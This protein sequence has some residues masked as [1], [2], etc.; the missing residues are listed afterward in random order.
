MGTIH[1]ILSNE[2][3][4]LLHSV[5]FCTYNIDRCTRLGYILGIPNTMFDQCN[6]F[7][8]YVMLLTIFLELI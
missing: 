4:F 6:L 7:F 1:Y 3:L 8:F 2:K 5:I